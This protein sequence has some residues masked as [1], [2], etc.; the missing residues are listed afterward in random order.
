MA[1]TKDTPRDFG[2]L[3]ESRTEL[4]VAA[5]TRVYQGAYLGIVAAS[6]H[7]AGLT[8]G[9]AFAGVALEPANNNP[10]AGGAMRVKAATRGQLRKV[11]VTGVSDATSI[12]AAVYA[13]ADDAL[14]L[15]SVRLTIE[16]PACGL[17]VQDHLPPGQPAAASPARPSRDLAR[18][19][20]AIS[21]ALRS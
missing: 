17:R 1:L 3:L 11:S 20:Q 21:A 8:A 13:S 4:R 7:V 19:L 12:G 14:T 10:G 9:E 5:N 6:G 15:R 18:R 16:C 2:A